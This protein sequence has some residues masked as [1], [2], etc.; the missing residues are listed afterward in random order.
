M[1]MVVNHENVRNIITY[2]VFLLAADGSYGEMNNW[3]ITKTA[4]KIEL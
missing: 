3:N 4:I 1:F 2:Q